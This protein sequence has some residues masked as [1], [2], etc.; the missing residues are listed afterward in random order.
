M[1]S[2]ENIYLCNI[3]FF[4]KRELNPVFWSNIKGTSSHL[5]NWNSPDPKRQVPHTIIIYLWKEVGQSCRRMGWNRIAS[6][7]DWSRWGWGREQKFSRDTGG[8][9]TSD[10]SLAQH[11]LNHWLKWLIKMNSCICLFLLQGLTLQSL[12]FAM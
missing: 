3:L 4:H 10:S 11:W 5:A 8:K 2:K 7:R 12:Q 1:N 9:T 6:A